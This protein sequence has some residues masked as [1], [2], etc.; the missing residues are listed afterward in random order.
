MKKT[1]HCQSRTR[2]REEEEKEKEEMERNTYE[3]LHEP[4]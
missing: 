4:D 2:T 3:D 1:K